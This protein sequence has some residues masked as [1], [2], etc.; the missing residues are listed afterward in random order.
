MYKKRGR[1]DI[2]AESANNDE[3]QFESQ[4]FNFMRKH[5]DII[6]RYVSLP[7]INL[8]IGTGFTP[9]SAGSTPDHQK[10]HV[11]DINEPTPCTLLYVKGSTIEIANII[12][13]ATHIMHGRPVTSKCA[14]VEMT[15]N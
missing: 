14:V 1:H 5:P 12:G 10:Y 7:Q 8:D 6:I 9:S 15:T 2:D 4:F 11:D 3:D 13:M